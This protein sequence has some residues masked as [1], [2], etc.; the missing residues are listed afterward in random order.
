VGAKLKG[1]GVDCAQLLV[2][3]YEALGLVEDVQLEPYNTQWFLHHTE[4]RFLAGV[5]SYC[6]RVGGLLAPLVP[7]DV[8]LYRYGR[9]VSHGAI[10]VAAD[11]VVHAVRKTGLVMLEECGPGSPLAERLDSVWRI[12][13]WHA[14]PTATAPPTAT[15]APTA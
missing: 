1:V 6:H 9:A 15:E 8:A 11:T 5:A 7:G 2:A 12:N 14:A 10:I 4:E 13:R 3:V